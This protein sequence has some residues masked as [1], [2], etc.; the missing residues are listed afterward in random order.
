MFPSA[1]ANCLNFWCLV[2]LISSFFFHFY[3]MVV[4]GHWSKVGIDWVIKKR[5]K[6]KAC[7]TCCVLLTERPVPV[8]VASVTAHTHPY[9]FPSFHLWFMGCPSIFL[10][11]F[12]FSFFALFLFV[13]HFLQL[14]LMCFVRLIYQC[15]WK[16]RNQNPGFSQFFSLLPE[17]LY[18]HL[19]I[20]FPLHWQEH[21]TMRFSTELI[22][23]FCLDT[24]Q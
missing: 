14:L 16:P 9:L 23:C 4:C 18:C 10:A 6:R 8:H 12:L 2:L 21:A 13:F 17:H 19:T 15:S 24:K 7:I 3:F 22:K 1:D 11:F 20:W 5:N